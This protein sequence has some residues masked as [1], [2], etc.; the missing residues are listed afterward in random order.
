MM[1][2]NKFKA[3]SLNRKSYRKFT[4][5]CFSVTCFKHVGL[6]WPISALDRMQVDGYAVITCSNI[7]I[8]IYICMYICIW[9]NTAMTGTERKSDLNSQK[10]HYSSPSRASYRVSVVKIFE[11]IDSV[12]TAFHCIINSMAANAACDMATEGGNISM[13]T[14]PFIRLQIKENLKAPRHWPLC[15]E[16]TGDR[17]IPRT[18]GQ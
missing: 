10:T 12:I 18:N 15:G 3:H 4:S 1:K 13:F 5:S 17:W 16:F 2:N 6:L 9:Y 11:M 8:H 14:Q 7:Y